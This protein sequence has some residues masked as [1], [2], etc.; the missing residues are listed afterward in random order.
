V[1]I[2]DQDAHYGRALSKVLKSQGDDVRLA[3]TAAGA[4]KAV[5]ERR[6]DLA[7]VDVL[8][9]GGGAELARSLS[10]R[11]RRLV[12][13]VGASMEGDELL[14]TALG[15]PVRRKATLPQLLGPAPP[16]DSETGQ[17]PRRSPARRRHTSARG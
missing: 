11:V 12:L 9:E 16:P 1:L 8:Q 15:F 3:T 10:R 13:S 5:R 17:P 7:I 4:L 2:V 14:E 6:Y